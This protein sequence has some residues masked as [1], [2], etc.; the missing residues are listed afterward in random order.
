[1]KKKKKRN[2][3][4]SFEKGES[5]M[6]VISLKLNSLKNNYHSLFCKI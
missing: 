5:G 4:M 3:V 2:S 6:N 1:M